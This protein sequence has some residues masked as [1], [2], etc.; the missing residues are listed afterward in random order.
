MLKVK[1]CGIRDKRNLEYLSDAAVD[2]VGFIFYEKSE[3]YF[4]KGSIAASEM[5]NFKKEK[6]GVFVDAEI[7]EMVF[8][9]KK[10]HLDYLQLHGN[11]SPETCLELKNKGFKVIK[12]IA[13]GKML[14][15]NL[16][17]YESTV[18]YFLFDTKGKLP[19]GNGQHFDWDCLKHYALKT[20][21]FLSGGIDPKDAGRIT[22]LHSDKLIAVDINSR[23]EIQPG[24]KDEGKIKH[25]IKQLKHEQI[26]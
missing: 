18:D 8:T 13:V 23:F 24:L 22:A 9:A 7:N 10:Y 19:G 11:E 1:V 12:A 21:Y 17:S 26:T 15:E 25:F 3:R 20:P 2:F 4:E 5:R 6:V 14:P 16:S